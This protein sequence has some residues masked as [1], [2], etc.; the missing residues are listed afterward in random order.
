M[1]PAARETFLDAGSGA[2]GCRAL[3]GLGAGSARL[4]SHVVGVRLH[5][6]QATAQL[7]V[8]AAA[9]AAVELRQRGPEWT[10]YPAAP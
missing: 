5:G 1:A 3:L 6:D 9:D 4:P 7:A 2:A 8:P 10:I